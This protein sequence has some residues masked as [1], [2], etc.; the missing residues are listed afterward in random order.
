MITKKR[1]A[2][3]KWLSI[4]S[5]LMV[6]GIQHPV[7]AQTSSISSDIVSALNNGDANR[8]STYLNDN[9][10]LFIENKNDIYSRQQ[11][12]SILNDFFHRYKVSDFKVIHQGN[13][14]NSSFTIG[15][16]STATE[17]FRVYILTR[18]SDNKTIIL[19]L[20]IEASNE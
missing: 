8:L 19:Q 5:F 13:K 14:E 15:I 6:V 3:F 11:A 2:H 10:E 12:V 1:I 4:L 17:N 7:Q 18:K 16:L 20:R 9:V